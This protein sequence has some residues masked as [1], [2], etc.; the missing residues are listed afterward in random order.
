MLFLNYPHILKNMKKIF[1]FILFAILTATAAFSAY[2]VWD[3]TPIPE[4]AQK[5]SASP[6]YCSYNEKTGTEIK[7]EFS[8][9]GKAK[10]SI[11]RYEKQELASQGKTRIVFHDVYTMTNQFDYAQITASL[12]IEKLD[13][14]LQ[15]AD[16]IVEIERKGAYTPV[17]T[18]ENA[19]TVSIFL[20]P[21]D[22]N[23]PAIS[24][25]SPADNSVLPPGKR[26]IKF[27][28]NL[29]ADLKTLNVF[30]QNQEV[31]A[32]STQ[33]T[34]GRY[35]FEFKEPI[36]K[37][38]E[39]SVKTIVTD[40]QERTSIGEWVFE[41]QL[42]IETILGKDRFNYLG[43]WGQINSDNVSVRKTPTSSAQQ[44]GYLSSINKVKVLEEVSG[45][46]IDG[47]NVWYKI[48]GGRYQGSYIFSGYVTP[49]AQP[50]PPE[51]LAVPQEVADG[52]YWI[53]VDLTKKILTLFLYDKPVFAT[54]VS[55]GTD[56]NPT[57]VGTFNVWY[58]L[59]KTEMKGGPPLV[60]Y[61]YDLFN[62]PS[63]MY[64]DNS[65][66][67][68]GTYWQD[69]FGTQQ[70]AGCTNLTKGDAAFIFEKTNPKLEEEKISV[71]SSE[72]NPG[73]VVH[74][75]K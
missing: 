74:N 67:V 5:Y 55:T 15:G 57:P 52:D 44:L 50:Q 14:T 17:E 4:Y 28:V 9:N 47:N 38:K 40:S 18:T 68:H 53:D 11:P 1:L 39:Y 24:N 7:F 25:Q 26:K 58:K 75:H 51:N 62:V 22:E 12:F 30:F 64:Y 6:L 70:S 48:D 34:P 43:W 32:S 49:I 59:K 3:R 33:I 16:L 56:A 27:E 54:Y 65:Y 63:V 41:G 71:L 73:T 69:K 29:K 46:D 60:N 2:F 72:S 31:A 35:L 37:D 36:E 45:E 10:N 13:Y 8:P 23:Y 21:G 42:A 66:A 19:N 20:R 61:R